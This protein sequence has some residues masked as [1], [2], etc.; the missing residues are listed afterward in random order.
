MAN[1]KISELTL[2]ATANSTDEIPVNRL[3]MNGKLTVASLSG[4]GL[5]V[6]DTVNPPIITQNMQFVG[7][8][9]S[10]GVVNTP[11]GLATSI[12]I[13]I[14]T[15]NGNSLFG[16]SNLSINPAPTWLE[17]NATDL[18]LWN[19]GKGNIASNTSFGESALRLNTS[20]SFNTAFGYNALNANTVGEKNTAIGSD[21]LLNLT[22][23]S[24]NIAVGVGAGAGITITN[25]NT[26]IGAFSSASSNSIAGSTVIGSGA[27][28]T[29]S[30]QFV[31]GSAGIIAGAVTTEVN[32]STQVW[33][34]IINGVARKILLA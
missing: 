4:N 18:T 22:T 21:T 31:V 29:A 13:G 32:S 8:G 6:Y 25:N 20:G 3:G 9:W 17:S 14:K 11:Y 2:F 16:T 30:N 5:K 33:N 15:I 27:T 12:E 24:R 34:V 28:A 23:G 19:N 26:F 10:L 7:T 1:K